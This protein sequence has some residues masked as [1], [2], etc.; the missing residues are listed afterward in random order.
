M[1]KNIEPKLTT[2]QYISDYKIKL[3][4]ANGFSSIFD[5]DSLL[6]P[7][8]SPLKNKKEFAQ[9]RRSRWGGLEWPCGVDFDIEGIYEE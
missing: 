9:V 7:T 2:V 3:T 5:F 8:N 1:L 6:Q 4:F